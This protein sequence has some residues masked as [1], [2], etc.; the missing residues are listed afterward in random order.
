MN[1]VLEKAEKD[2]NNIREE[3]E[4]IMKAVDISI[5]YCLR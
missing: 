4:N 2:D 5:Y 3:N 1:E